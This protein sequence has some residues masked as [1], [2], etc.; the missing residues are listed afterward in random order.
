MNRKITVSMAITLALIAMTVTFSVTMIV[1]MRMFDNT[2]SSV[3]EKES[4][5]TKL[6]ELDRYVR[7]NEYYEIK[8]DNLNDMMASGY[9]LG[10]GDRYARYYTAKGYSDYLDV[11]S[12][13]SIGI[14]VT[15]VND[16]SSG[17]ARITAVY[18]DTPASEVGMTVNGYIT[19]INDV[20]VKNYTTNEAIAA[21]LRGEAGTTVT[22]T[23]LSPDMT[24]NTYEITR[25]SY[26]VPTLTNRILENVG[27]IGI[28]SLNEST[29]T[30]FSYAVNK[31]INNGA[32]CLVVDLRGVSSSDLASALSCVDAILPEGDVAYARYKN[33]NVELLGSSDASSISQPVVC[34]VDT[35]TSNA[36][37]LIAGAVQLNGGRIVGQRT[38]GKGVVMGSPVRM[39]DGSAV[40]I[41][42][43]QLLLADM[44]TF[45]GAGLLPDTEVALGSDEFITVGETAAECDAQLRK[46]MEVAADMAANS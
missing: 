10:T 41:T 20:D 4:Q 12:G 6:A 21:A 9:L 42:R 43:A 7:A 44:E 17:Y 39:S 35:A 15:A 16:P 37:E 8:D 26:A 5:Y 1:A 2:V 40:V 3:N 34:L 18:A 31:L 13:K 23:Y 46:A 38:A 36:A 25:R 30:D 33:G 27:Y 45:D 11:Q 29:P 28:V 14:G 32:E 22:V 19:R 24:E